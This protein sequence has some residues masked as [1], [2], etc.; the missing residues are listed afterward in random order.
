MRNTS[1]ITI[2]GAIVNALNRFGV[3]RGLIIRLFTMAPT[4]SV[5]MRCGLLARVGVALRMPAP[6]RLLRLLVDPRLL[7][8]LLSVVLPEPAGRSKTAKQH[9]VRLKWNPNLH[10]WG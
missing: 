2:F 7:R 10:V 9:M 4:S 3:M 1:Q 8:L 5:I 6:S